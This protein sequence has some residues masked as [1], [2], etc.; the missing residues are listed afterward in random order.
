MSKLDNLKKKLEEV[1]SEIK[2][3]ESQE[4]KK[5]PMSFDE[6]RR[7]GRYWGLLAEGSKYFVCFSGSAGGIAINAMGTWANK[8]DMD[9]YW[10]NDGDYL[11]FKYEFIKFNTAKELYQWLLDGED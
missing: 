2:K 10:K 7:S 11:G 6:A 9:E 4:K 5:W 3:L 8:D 1:Q